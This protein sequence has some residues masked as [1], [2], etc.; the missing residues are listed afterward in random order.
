MEVLGCVSSTM[1]LCCSLH[2]VIRENYKH[3]RASKRS[4]RRL[5]NLM[6]K[7]DACKK[8]VE[9]EV[10]RLCGQNRA[11]PTN[12]CV[13]WFERADQVNTE[14]SNLL[15]ENGS[16]RPTKGCCFICSRI[17]LGKLIGEKIRD[18]QELLDGVPRLEDYSI[19]VPV[20]KRGDVLSAIPM[21]EYETHKQILMEIWG[22]LLDKKA[23]RIGIWGIG[24][25]GK[26]TIMSEIHNRLVKGR[27]QFNC[28]IWV[29][30]SK[31]PRKVQQDI[32][33]RL[34]LTFQDA[35]D[36]R[37]RASKLLEAF[38]RK[39]TFALILDEVWEPLSIEEV[40][41][42]FPTAEN[43][44]KLVIITRSRTVC[45]D[46]ETDKD[47]EVKLLSENE[48]WNLFNDKAG[49][50]V[51]SDPDVQSI[52]MEVA[53][54]CCGLP[55]AIVTVGRAL[56]NTVDI[57]E[58]EDALQELR[59]STTSIH[60]FEEVVYSRLKLSY[61]KL[62]DDARRYCF[63]FCALY[64]KGHLID[65]NELINYWVWEDLL[66]GGSM[67]EMKRKGQKIIRQLISACLL[68]LKIENGVRYVKLH[69]LI[70][71]MA[72][73]IM[74]TK[75]RCIVKAG[76]GQVKLPPPQEWKEDVQWASLMRNDV[77]YIRFNP[78]CPRLTS[79]LLQ[80]NSFEQNISDD[81][82]DNMQG[83]K[84][85][86]LSYTGIRALP[87]SLSDLKN[88]HALI[89]SQCWNFIRVP[90]L[91]RLT[92]LEYL[93]FSF[94]RS[95]TELPEG[96][97][98]LTNLKHLD[99]S[100]TSVQNL[101]AG[102]LSKF[103]LLEELLILGSPMMGVSSKSTNSYSYAVGVEEIGYCHKLS[104]VH[105]QLR[106][107]TA[108]RRIVKCLKFSQL[109]EFKLVVGSVAGYDTSR[110]F[111][112]T[113]LAIDLS[114]GARNLSK[115]EIT[116]LIPRNVM[117]LVI[118]NSQHVIKRL[119]LHLLDAMCLKTCDITWCFGMECILESVE[120]NLW[121]LEKMRLYNLPQLRMICGEVVKP[122]TL[123]NLKSI[124]VETCGSLKFLFQKQLILELKSLEEITIVGCPR[125]EEIIEGE[126]NTNAEGSSHAAKVIIPK[127][128]RLKLIDLLN[129]RSIYDGDIQCDSLRTIEVFRCGALN[130]LPLGLFG[131]EE[132]Q[133]I[134]PSTTTL[135]Q[136]SCETEWWESLQWD[137]PQAKH[138]LQPYLVVHPGG[139]L[140]VNHMPFKK[141]LGV[142]AFSQES[143]E[144][145]SEEKI[146][147]INELL[148]T[149]PREEY[150][151]P[152]PINKRGDVLSATS[153][154]E[155]ETHKQIFMKIW[156]FLLDENARR[157]GVWGM[158]GVGKTTIM[159]EINNCLVKGS[160]QF[161]CTLW[162]EASK[163]L[164]KMQQDIAV[165][166]GLTFQETDDE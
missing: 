106:D 143:S 135:E 70:R 17:K 30:A 131:I 148:E 126:R 47:V 9:H 161:N 156:G 159:S 105:M 113:S 138:L 164:K 11:E 146:I 133:Q 57:R 154:I 157:I 12:E 5:D 24:G 69:D 32:A 48:A 109:K 160:S 50:L 93:D 22:F 97:E 29:E 150:S 43:G 38:D 10:N 165:K 66:G 19:A 144:G 117:E 54:Q 68:E 99:F 111:E 120:N 51:L 76:M 123:K 137:Q 58:W 162:V 98:H 26:T 119:S 15:D 94:S 40:G 1:G 129:L 55:L 140:I 121:R 46:M 147:D 102:L 114:V 80:C 28:I 53:K 6:Q 65:E 83:L 100:F 79:L 20:N 3:F 52:A 37:A 4:I 59:T 103:T 35:D 96:M 139:R 124:H 2:E 72:L 27:S 42:P 107:I 13:F 75:P 82:F 115:A 134:S 145:N 142:V 130:K 166:L 136:I 34:G 92:K 108:Y 89:C 155:Y 90:S 23:R 122:G 18:I 81:F 88:L 67:A 84:V 74:S 127:L 62:E 153:M 16:H 49:E 149:V 56:R 60:N 95:L 151:I 87:M 8:D 91:A 64:P 31:D 61:S 116:E 132:G 71:D 7:L 125:M 85:L 77:K 41:I 33:R 112:R 152:I 21:V 118:Q 110:L 104:L 45:K 141:D 36:E 163:D 25:V 44:C 128:Q 101:G 73:T 78:M 158:G 14:V 39:K 63:L 86:D